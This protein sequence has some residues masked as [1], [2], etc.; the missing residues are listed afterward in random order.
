[1]SGR[2]DD[3]TYARRLEICSGCPDLQYGTT[4]RHCGCLVAVRVKLAAKGCPNSAPKWDAHLELSQ[5]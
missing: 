2:A 3:S 5:N 4:C 1:M